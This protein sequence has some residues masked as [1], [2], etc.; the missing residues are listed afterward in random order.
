LIHGIH[1]GRSRHI[2]LRI[3][4]PNSRQIMGEGWGRILSLLCIGRL[5]GLRI[6]DRQKGQSCTQDREQSSE[7]CAK[8]LPPR[9]T[10]AI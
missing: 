7:P 3:L 2:A 8:N 10:V 6:R 1:A 9:K 4:H 5:T